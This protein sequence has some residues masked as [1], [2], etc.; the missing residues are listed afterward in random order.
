MMGRAVSDDNAEQLISKVFE[1]A[2]PATCGL[3]AFCHRFRSIAG[4]FDMNISTHPFDS[5]MEITSRPPTVFVR[6]EGS[7]LWDDSG[8]R[9]LDFVQGW[10][11]NCLGHSPPAVVDALA[12][13]S[14]LL[15]TPSPAFYNAPSLKLAKALVDRSCFDQV[16]FANS[17]AE[18][19]EGA[20]KL[21]RKFGALHRNGAYEIIT[22]EGG[23]H[24]RTLATM[25]ASGKKAFEPLFEPKVSG[26][27]KARLNDL[28]S[29]Q[30]LITDKTIAVM[31]EPIQGEAGVWPATD[32]FLRDLRSL[33][34]AHGLLLI[35]DEIQTGMG[36]TGKLFHYEHPGIEPDIMT[37]GKGIG[38]GVP[39]AA[40]L[41]TEAA[42]CF[43]HGDQGG[44]FNGNPLMCA[45]GLAVLEQVNEPGFLKAV[46][47]RGLY[48]ESELQRISA[49]HGLGDI[50]G[51]GLLLALDLRIPIAAAIVAQAFADGVLLNAPRPDALRFM[52]ALNVTKAE[53]AAM[54]DC[55]D[56][57]LTKIGAARRVA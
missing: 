46:V 6:G 53:I 33:T 5:L 20:I 56:A 27:P 54:I 40:L 4:S 41:A 36:R 1:K 21:A 47:D 39:L 31:L 37:L 57:I 50:R 43:E 32:H 44:T 9:Y 17:G 16:F 8:K 15:L 55:L 11:V 10:A 13:Q 34:K 30:R 52:P 28:A 45:A 38:G 42:S 26:F 24:G 7:F 12:A 19:N 22:F 29:V 18:A 48:L 51:K 3:L 14:K 2:A 35:V 49:R 25:S 23:F